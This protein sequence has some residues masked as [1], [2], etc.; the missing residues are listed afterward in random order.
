MGFAEYYYHC[1]THLLKGITVVKL[2]ISFL[3]GM[4]NEMETEQEGETEEITK[5]AGNANMS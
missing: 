2:E 5:K 1:S 4:K 3:S